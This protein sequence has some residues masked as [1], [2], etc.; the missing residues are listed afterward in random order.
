MHTSSWKWLNLVAIIAVIA[1]N[2][3]ANIIPFNGVTTGDVSA[4]YPVLLT[5]ATYA[6]TIWILIYTLLVGFACYQL[7]PRSETT[8]RAIGPLF[9]L[10]CLFNITWIVLW[11]YLYDQVWLSLIAMFGLFISLVF[12]YRSVR[13]HRYPTTG[14]KWLVQLPFSIY[15]GWITVATIVNIDVALYAIGW[16]HFGWSDQA[17]TLALLAIG[18][19]LAWVIGGPNRDAAFVLVFVWAY[20]AIAWNNKDS[21]A[22]FYSALG[23][24]TLLALL[25]VALPFRPRKRSVD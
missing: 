23:F 25:A 12:I 14:Q 19:F 20:V 13:N 15:F 5:P 16:N 6:F 22:I 10:S 24:S 9:V 8:V 18:T 7:L 4:M 11:H 17:W 1:I 3:L 2:G 21:A